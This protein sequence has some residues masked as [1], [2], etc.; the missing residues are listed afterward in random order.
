MTTIN[1]LWLRGA[2]PVLAQVSIASYR[3]QGCQVRLYSYGLE[4]DV[5]DGVEVLDANTLIPERE[6]MRHVFQPTGQLALVGDVV[7]WHA[8]LKHGG[9]NGHLDLT[10]HQPLDD[11]TDPYVFAPHHAHTPIQALWKA[12]PNSPLIRTALTSISSPPHRNWYACMRAMARA[13]RNLF[14]SKYL[15]NDLVGGNDSSDDPITHMLRHPTIYAGWE[16]ARSI[17]WMGSGV[18]ARIKSEAGSFYDNLRRELLG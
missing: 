2:L 1:T 18:F 12:P 14:L 7:M 10:L 4:S 9:W 11:L 6:A 3:R 17:H 8:S 13:Y 15:R 5:P 16:N